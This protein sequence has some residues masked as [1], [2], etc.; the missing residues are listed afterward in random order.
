[1]SGRSAEV[2]VGDGKGNGEQL[3]GSA[4]H[5]GLIYMGGRDLQMQM[6]CLRVEIAGG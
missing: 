6:Q 4:G 1:M 5:S 2:E 3:Q